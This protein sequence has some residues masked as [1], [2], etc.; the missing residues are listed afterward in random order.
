MKWKIVTAGVVV[1]AG[2]G[3][4][5]C[6]ATADGSRLLGTVECNNC[7]LGRPAP[8][9][10]TK[11]FLLHY[12][13]QLR[14][15]IGPLTDSVPR[16]GTFWSSVMRKGVWTI[17]GL[18]QATLVRISGRKRPRPRQVEDASAAEME[19]P[20]PAG[21]AAVDRLQVAEAGPVPAP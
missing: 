7:G 5:L 20:G 1:V 15:S 12:E 4:G 19:I 21:A 9:V 3:W 10:G 17:A 2:F 11:A 8:D 14:L 6:V 18:S 16:T 13:S